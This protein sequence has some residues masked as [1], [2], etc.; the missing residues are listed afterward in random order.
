MNVFCFT[1]NLGRDA[2]VK[3]LPSGSAV[4][5][6]SVAATAG[7]GTRK[8]TLWIKCSLWGKRAEG[9][10]PELLVKGQSVAVSGE[11]SMREWEG[12]DGAMRKELELNV[13]DITLIGQ[14]GAQ[15]GSPS[16]EFQKAPPVPQGGEFEDDIPF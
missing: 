4:C 14:K 6:F 11:L 3:Y 16:Q 12:K 2:E 9:S 15:P 5:E 10:L 7:Y 1:G 8:K 13:N